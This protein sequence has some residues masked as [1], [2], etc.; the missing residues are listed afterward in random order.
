MPPYCCKNIVFFNSKFKGRIS[1]IIKLLSSNLN[2][3]TE[4]LHIS[5]DMHGFCKM[6]ISIIRNARLAE[7]F[8]SHLTERSPGIMY[9]NAI[10]EP[11]NTSWS[12]SSL[13][14][15]MKDSIA[16]QL[17]KSRKWIL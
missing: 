2:S 5:Q 13:I 17:L 12:V 11:V 4:P 16:N 6:G 9:F 8:F 1:V 14:G 10:R 3:H 7:V 15:S